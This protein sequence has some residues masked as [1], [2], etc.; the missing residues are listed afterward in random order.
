MNTIQLPPLTELQSRELLSELLPDA[1]PELHETVIAAAEGNP[2]FT[3]EI[4]RH[5]HQRGFATGVDPDQVEAA[6]AIV[7]PYLSPR[8]AQAPA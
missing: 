8:V 7:R 2:L 4:V 6:V 5:L 3:E 1:R